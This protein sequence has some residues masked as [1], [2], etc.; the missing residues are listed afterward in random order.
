MDIIRENVRV[1]IV[2]DSNTGKTMFLD[3]IKSIQKE[4]SQSKCYSLL[5][6][7]YSSATKDE[8]ITSD[9]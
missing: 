8:L 5:I 7:I 4:M 3:T 1:F 2:G 6:L 9:M